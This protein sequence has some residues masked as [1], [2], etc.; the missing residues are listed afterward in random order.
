[1]YSF[2][3]PDSAV[4]RPLGVPRD[5]SP[6]YASAGM[7]EVRP[8]EVAGS[9]YP[10]DAT[11]L[12]RMVEE[13][14]DEVPAERRRA[15]AAIV[16]HAGL[17]YSGKCAG[18]VLGRLAIP[19][20]VVILAP[21]HTGRYRS[22]GASLWARGA[23]QTPLGLTSVDEQIAMRLEQ[24]CELVAHDPAAH[25]FEHAIEV[26][27]PFLQVLSPRTRIVP[28][29]IAWDDWESCEQLAAALTRIVADRPTDIL[30]LASSDMTHHES[31]SNA[32]R[33][34]S[35]VLS[36]IEK[37]D[38]RALLDACKRF[39][40]TMCGRACAAVAVET[41]RRLGALRARVIDYRHS[42][43]VTG[44]DDRVVAYAGVIVA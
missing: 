24:E 40:V 7:S 31:A 44:D 9:F 16:P 37:L 19:S 23:F 4:T 11:K 6:R 3:R 2:D 28:L 17:L 26:E 38:G 20:V 15:R 39:D 22:P 8:S 25:R 43:M 1:M 10:H 30:V 34:D 5:D 12:R 32:F 27:L 42:G 29:V 36:A 41:A 33:K 13:C 18:A 35:N 21:N 14:L